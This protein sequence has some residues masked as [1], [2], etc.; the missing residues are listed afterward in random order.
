[1]LQAHNCM[2]LPKLIKQC[3]LNLAITLF[4]NH[5]LLNTNEISI[6]KHQ[7][8]IFKGRKWI[9]QD[10]DYE[11]KYFLVTFMV[12]DGK[13]IITESQKQNF[14]IQELTSGRKQLTLPY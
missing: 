7:Y 3:T 6:S 12:K 4:E 8:K 9:Y 5:I 2:R 13:P 10:D 1:M 14:S 11:P